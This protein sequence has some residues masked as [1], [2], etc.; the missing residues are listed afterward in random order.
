MGNININGKTAVH[1]KSDGQ[2]ITQD[3][4]LTPSHCVP[5]TY[6]NQAESKMADMTA[7]SVKIQ[8]SPACHQQSNFKI[9]KG[10]GPGCCGGTSSGTTQQMAEFI[11]GSQDVT[12]EGKP[13][14]RNG[15]KMVSNLKNTPPQPLQQPPAGEAKA[16]KVAPIEQ[17]YS[18]QFKCTSES[19]EPVVKARYEI[20]TEDGQIIKG[21]TNAQGMTQ[22]IFTETAQTL[23]VR[24]G[25]QTWT[26]EAD[27]EPCC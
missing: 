7:S 8:D 24:F 6:T 12:I 4:C 17:E 23:D 11:I 18:Q 3:T 21:Y 27:D 13:A 2:L 1:A 16:G 22:R 20:H 26:L 15:D 9:S 5:I 25:G 14:V 19:G 10:D